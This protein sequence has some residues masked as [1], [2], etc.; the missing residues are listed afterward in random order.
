MEA[1]CIS[2]L[3][4][5]VKSLYAVY[6]ACLY[7]CTINRLNEDLCFL[8]KELMILTVRLQRS[9]VMSQDI[10]VINRHCCLEE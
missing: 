1:A 7:L 4:F 3:E 8:C 5:L 2:L 10:H 6:I 9:R